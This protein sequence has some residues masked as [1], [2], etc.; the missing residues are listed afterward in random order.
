MNYTK[1]RVVFKDYVELAVNE[2]EVTVFQLAGG[3]HRIDYLNDKDQPH[4]TDGPA[5]VWADG[6]QGW[7]E[8]GVCSKI[9]KAG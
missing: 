6:W 5:C 3:Y 8:N 2:D 7:Y 4:R 1:I 9:T